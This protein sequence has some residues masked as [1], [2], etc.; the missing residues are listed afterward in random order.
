M[1]P[2]YCRSFKFARAI[3][4]I[5]TTGHGPFQEQPE[6]FRKNLKSSWQV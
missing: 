4:R 1:D 6:L 2:T 5:L 3:C